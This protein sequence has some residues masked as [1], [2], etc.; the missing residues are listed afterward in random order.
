MEF[1]V[2]REILAQRHPKTAAGISREM[3]WLLNDR[4]DFGPNGW[5]TLVGKNKVAS[6]EATARCRRTHFTMMDGAKASGL[7]QL[8]QESFWR[9]VRS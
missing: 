8:H 1:A 9:H 4:T 2:S 3:L 6:I 7:I 5:D